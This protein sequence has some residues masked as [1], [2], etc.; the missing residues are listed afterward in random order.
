M[1]L[2]EEL[3]RRGYQ[4]GYDSV[5]RHV[6]AWKAEHRGSQEVFIPLHFAPGEAFQFGWGEETLNVVRA[7]P[8]CSDPLGEGAIRT[9]KLEPV[10]VMGNSPLGPRTSDSSRGAE[11][12]RS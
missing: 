7:V 4:G 8:M 6:Q 3:Q 10:S 9:R 2:S 1:L 5:R 11:V 12:P